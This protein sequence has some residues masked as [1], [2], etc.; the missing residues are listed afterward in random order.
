MFIDRGPI[1]PRGSRPR[2]A[3]DIVGPLMPLELGQGRIDVAIRIGSYA[4]GCRALELRDTSGRAVLSPTLSVQP[5]LIADLLPDLPDDAVIVAI[6]PSALRSGIANVLVDAGLLDDLGLEVPA[7]RSFGRLMAVN[8]SALRMA[9]AR[10]TEAAAQARPYRLRP[11][12][13]PPAWGVACRRLQAAFRRHGAIISEAEAM[14][15]WASAS[16]AFARMPPP[17]PPTA[18]AIHDMLA[19][20]FTPDQ[21]PNGSPSA[22]QASNIADQETRKATE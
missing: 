10:D 7:E 2:L 14:L 3:P 9:D 21:K 5:D 22:N 11:L 19:P 1:R 13:V 4:N 15:A 18:E 17:L 20:Y 8:V 16:G 6:K 12:K